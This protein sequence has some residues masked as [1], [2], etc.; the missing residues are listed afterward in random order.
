M[1]KLLLAAHNQRI[2]LLRITKNR[3]L[4]VIIGSYYNVDFRFFNLSL[5]VIKV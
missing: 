4:S 1:L 5:L 2:E 3:V